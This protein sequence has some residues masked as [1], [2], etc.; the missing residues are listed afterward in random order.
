MSEGVE[1]KKQ[2]AKGKKQ[3]VSASLPVAVYNPRF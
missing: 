2:K 3:K 1:S